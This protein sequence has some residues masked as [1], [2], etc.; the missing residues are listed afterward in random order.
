[1]REGGGAGADIE[2]FG[3]VF[4]KPLSTEQGREPVLQALS[5]EGLD[6][7]NCESEPQQDTYTIMD[8]TACIV[9]HVIVNQARVCFSKQHRVKTP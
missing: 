5:Y 9:R 7:T 1:M 6:C 4:L 3:F 8:D 2:A